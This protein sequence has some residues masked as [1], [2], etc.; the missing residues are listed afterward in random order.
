MRNDILKNSGM[1]N[2]EK[3][4]AIAGNNLVTKYRKEIN[5]LLE[6]MNKDSQKYLKQIRDSDDPRD[7]G[8]LNQFRKVESKTRD[9]LPVFYPILDTK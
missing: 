3:G 8:K 2:E 5:N 6:E 4:N 7:F 9:L 1:I